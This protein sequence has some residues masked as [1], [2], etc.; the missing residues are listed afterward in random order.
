[1]SKT[2]I[3]FFLDLTL[4]VCFVVVAWSAAVLRFVFPPATQAQGWVL[5]GWDYDEWAWL[6]FGCLAAFGVLVLLHVMLHWS[7][8]CGVVAHRL[9]R[10]GRKVVLND[11]QQTVFGV[12]TLLI[13]LHVVGIVF[14][15]AVL[16]IQEP[17]TASHQPEPA[18]VAAPLRSNR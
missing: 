16:T 1:M 12:A 9:S 17:A 2:I 15:A 13:L 10:G 7:W 5:W 18:S 3:N 4:A 8:V 6:E 11:S 14:L